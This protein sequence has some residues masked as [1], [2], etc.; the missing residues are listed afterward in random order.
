LKIL[1]TFLL[2]VLALFGA[3]IAH[4]ALSWSTKALL[5]LWSPLARDEVEEKVYQRAVYRTADPALRPVIG[6]AAAA[7]L[8]WGLGLVWQS[9]FSSWLMF[10]GVMAVMAALVMDLQRWDRVAVTASFVWFQRG[11]GNTVHRV[12]LNNVIEVLVQEKDEPCITLRRWRKSRSARLA[13]RTADKRL[14]S[15]PKT[16]AFS[17]LESIEIMA[18]FL[19]HRLQKNRE[20]A[21][22][23]RSQ[24][25]KLGARQPAV[26][27]MPAAPQATHVRSSSRAVVASESRQRGIFPV[28]RVALGG[29]SI[30]EDASL[31]RAISRLLQNK[32]VPPSDEQA[33]AETQ[34]L[35]H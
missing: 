35:T 6:M 12:S 34:I 24:Q 10:S 33:W 21:V 17:G 30:D 27:P 2:L 4:A 32:T 19:R 26:I 16:D 3:L 9:G 14:V 25:P 18:N 28:P 8:A 11:F 7:G 23:N 15:L 29:S 13:I 20:A 31:Q 5:W 22:P 1:E